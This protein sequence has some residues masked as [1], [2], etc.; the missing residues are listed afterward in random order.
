MDRLQHSAWRY[1]AETLAPEE[2]PMLAAQT[3]VDGR[4]SPALRELA[5]LTRRSDEAEIGELYVLAL[6]ELGVRLPDEETAGRWLLVSLAVALAKAELSPKEV[7]DRLS[8][9]VAARTP[10]ETQFL[11]IAAD[12][13]EW[14]GADELPDWEDS[15]R[16]AAHALTASSDLASGVGVPRTAAPTDYPACPVPGTA[17]SHRGTAVTR[18]ETPSVHDTDRQ[19]VGGTVKPVSTP[20]SRRNAPAP[21]CDDVLPFRA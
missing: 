21:I 5:G 20:R 12:Y 4:D 3:L 1:V 10:E 18:P 6:C 19:Q 2:L 9:T 14:M 15:L 8:M 17:E 13:S 7:V 16:T 11:S